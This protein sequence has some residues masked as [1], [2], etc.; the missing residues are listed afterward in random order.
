M[1]GVLCPPPP[2]PHCLYAKSVPAP[3]QRHGWSREWLGYCAFLLLLYSSV[4]DMWCGLFFTQLVYLFNRKKTD[5]TFL[6]FPNLELIGLNLFPASF[7]FHFRK[8][9]LLKVSREREG[10]PYAYLDYIYACM[11]ACEIMPL[12][13]LMVGYNSRSIIFIKNRSEVLNIYFRLPYAYF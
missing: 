13:K 9:I 6:S 1:S 2:T 5:L 7:C 10:P 3:T 11:H 12:I 4:L 8:L